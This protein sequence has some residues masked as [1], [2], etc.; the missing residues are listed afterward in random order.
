MSKPPTIPVHPA[1]CYR[2]Q[3]LVRS[4]AWNESPAHPNLALLVLTS[5]MWSACATQ[6]HI[7]AIEHGLTEVFLT[8][9]LD[10]LT[11][12]ASA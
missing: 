10:R 1:G 2:F 8:H 12:G 5:L 4:G 7:L 3:S 6:T 11:S 9:R